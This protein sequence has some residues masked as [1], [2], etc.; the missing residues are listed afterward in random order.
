LLKL[1]DKTDLDAL[2]AELLGVVRETMQPTHRSLW[3]RDLRDL[4]D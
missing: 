4:S 2:N 3:Q 1:G